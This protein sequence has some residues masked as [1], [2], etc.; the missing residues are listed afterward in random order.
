MPMC[1]DPAAWSGP[2]ACWQSSPS[3]SNGMRVRQL[4]SGVSVPCW[5][6][7]VGGGDRLSMQ[8]FCRAA[9]V[10][11]RTFCV[12]AAR[13]LRTTCPPSLARQI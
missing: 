11:A 12:G 10:C 13:G 2:R 7:C 1:W 3:W 8:L 4:C 6:S 9:C 5:R